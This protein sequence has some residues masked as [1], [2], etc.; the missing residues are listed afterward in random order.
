MKNGKVVQVF[1]NFPL[2]IHPNAPAAAMAALCAGDQDPKLFWEMHDWLFA[3]QA[4]WQSTTDAAGQLRTQAETFGIDR[5]KY[6]A[7]ITDTKTQAKI[8]A[9]LAAGKVLGVSGTPAFF[10]YKMQGGKETGSPTSLEG[11]QPFDQFQ[12]AIDALLK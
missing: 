1:R 7:C 8:Q 3:N 12:Q 6:D 9:D 4:T 5:A 10:L 2:D 11:A